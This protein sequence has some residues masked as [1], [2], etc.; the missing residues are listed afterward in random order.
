ME[1]ILRTVEK[2]IPKKLY[3]LG[4]PAYHYLLTLVG[5]I[6][7]G[8]PA[9]KIK[10]IGVTGTKGKSS[11]TEIINHILETAGKKTAVSG[12]IR[13]KV[14]THQ[15]PNKFKMSMP[16]RFFMQK[17]LYDAV[18][19]GCEFAVIEM[20]SEGSKQFRHKFI[21]TD[22]FV[23]T[24]FSPEHIESHGSYEA[25]K[26]AKV[27][28]VH[29]LKKKNG[30]LLL[31]SDDADSHLFSEAYTGP[32]ETYSLFEAENIVTEPTISFTYQKEEIA[33]PLQGKFNAYNI[34]AAIHVSRH[35]DI[36]FNVIQ[37]ALATQ[38]EIAGRVQKIENELGAEIVVDYAHTPD[39]LIALY[40]SFKDK[41]KV[42]IL[43]NTGGGRDTWKRPKMAE[44]AN[45]YCDHVIL[46]NEDP[47]EEDPMQIINDMKDSVTIEK[48]DIILD[49]K[50]AIAHGISMLKHGDALLITGKGT[51][52]YIME[53]GGKKTPWSDAQVVR[54]VLEG[55]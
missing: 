50:E 22:A 11:T 5:A 35:F 55:R 20:T 15:R 41:R 24:N 21:W 47:Y 18:K 42:C 12:T 9:R 26:Q 29:N 6:R 10:I 34:L 27:R 19:A 32:T 54:D 53:A 7:Y 4:Q 30:L 28:M 38:P 39:S 14:G 44:I 37:K 33:S 48:L 16:G 13:F 46:T 40:E 49:R 31:N 8:F 23:F 1:K 25:Y 45:S 17:F 51:D 2:V 52:P 43:G 3:T 36:P